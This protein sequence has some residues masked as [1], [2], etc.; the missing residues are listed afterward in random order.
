MAETQSKTEGDFAQVATLG[1][2]AKMLQSI[3][4]LEEKAGN[5]SPVDWLTT[6]ATTQANFTRD[7]AEALTTAAHKLV[8]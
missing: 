5:A 7:L 1:A 8:E 2:Y 3:A 6:F 4:E